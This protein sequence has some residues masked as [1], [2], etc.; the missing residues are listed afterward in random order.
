MTIKGDGYAS[1]HGGCFIQFSQVDSVTINGDGYTSTHG[2][3]CISEGGESKEGD[4]EFGEH[5]DK[6]G[7]RSK[8]IT[9]REEGTSPVG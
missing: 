3:C 2:G 4:D 8:K 5:G 9:I 1:T 7:P 6:N